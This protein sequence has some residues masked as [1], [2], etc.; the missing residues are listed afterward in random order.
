M[1]ETKVLRPLRS[2]DEPLTPPP[3]SPTSMLQLIHD[4]VSPR[5]V[6][7]RSSPG[8]GP[9]DH[10]SASRD[11]RFKRR[12]LLRLQATERTM[13]GDEEGLGGEEEEEEEEE[14]EDDS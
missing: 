13:R 2:C 8:A 5:G 1:E 12:Q 10:H 7:T 3:H 6:V 11:E 14:E 4:P 9:S